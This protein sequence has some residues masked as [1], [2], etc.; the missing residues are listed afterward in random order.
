[1]TDETFSNWHRIIR[2]AD[3]PYLQRL[4]EGFERDVRH[5]NR[6]GDTD[7]ADANQSLLEFCREQMQ[8]RRDSY[9][10]EID[11]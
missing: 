2:A 8:N 5:C 6:L 11:S 7:N 3:T 10:G 1:M 9:T 4:T